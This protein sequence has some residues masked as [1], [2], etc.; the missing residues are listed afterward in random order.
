[1]A[2]AHSPTGGAAFIGLKAGSMGETSTLACLIGAV[3]LI[4]TGIGSWRTMFGVTLGT[5]AMACSSTRSAPTPTRC[6]PS[7]SDWHMVLGGWAFGTVFMAT[8]PVSS[9]F[10]DTW[11]KVDLRHPDRRDGRARPRGQ[12][13]LPRGHDAGD[14]VHEHVRAAHRL[15]HR[16]A[17]IKR[18]LA[19]HAR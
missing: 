18:R 1:M 11:G 2:S 10:T 3:I 15:L 6:S 8:D 19:R 4:V 12:P 5:F 13:R 9:A 16:A 7:R 14:P 17:N